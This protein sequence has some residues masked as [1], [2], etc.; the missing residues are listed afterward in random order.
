MRL[1]GHDCAIPLAAA[2]EDDD[3]TGG[4]QICPHGGG[5]APKLRDADFLFHNLEVQLAGLVGDSYWVTVIAHRRPS[6][7]VWFDKVPVCMRETSASILAQKDFQ[8]N[9]CAVA[10]MKF[11]A[12]HVPLR[13]SMQVPLEMT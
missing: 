4:L 5:L 2:G 11:P 10:K 3:V 9:G 6:S 8:R 13:G 7:E 12:I 1:D